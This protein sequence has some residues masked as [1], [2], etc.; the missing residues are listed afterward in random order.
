MVKAGVEPYDSE[1]VRAALRAGCSVLGIAK[2]QPNWS[3]DAIKRDAAAIGRTGLISAFSRPTELDL[4]TQLDKERPAD[5]ASWSAGV[6]R[7]HPGYSPGEL[8]KLWNYSKRVQ[9]GMKPAMGAAFQPPVSQQRELVKIA[10]HLDQPEARERLGLLPEDAKQWTLNYAVH[11]GELAEDTALSLGMMGLTQVTPVLTAAGRVLSRLPGGARIAKVAPALSHIPGARGAIARTAYRAATGAAEMQAIQPAFA[12]PTLIQHGGKAYLRSQIP[13]KETLPML[14]FGAI[15]KA[16]GGAVRAREPAPARALGPD[17]ATVPTEELLT[18]HTTW[19]E[20]PKQTPQ[21]AARLAEVQGELAKRAA[22]EVAPAPVAPPPVEVAK[23]VAPPEVAA[24]PARLAPHEVRLAPVQVVETSSV[25]ANPPRFQY[26]ETNPPESTAY[27]PA[28]AGVLDTWVD[29]ATGQRWVVNGNK[30]LAW[31]N[32]DAAPTVQVQDVLVDTADAARTFGA[33]KNISENTGTAVDAAKLFRGSGITPD[34]LQ[35]WGISLRGRVAR[36]G[37]GLSGLADDIFHKVAN[38]GELTEAQGSLIGRY[39]PDGAD[40]RVLADLIAEGERTGRKRIT[41]DMIPDVAAEIQSTPKVQRTETTLFGT[42]TT[43]ASTWHERAS[44][45]TWV[46]RE[47]TRDRMAFEVAAKNAERL[48]RGNNVIDEATSAAIAQK[49]GQAGEIYDRLK[50][51]VGPVNTALNAAAE[52]LA[53]GEKPDVVKADFY[54]ETYKAVEEIVAHG[55]GPSLIGPETVTPAAPPAV[56]TPAEPTPAPPVA[57]TPP[58]A[59]PGVAGK[60]PVTKPPAAGVEGTKPGVATK[61]GAKPTLA[62]VEEASAARVREAVPEAPPPA[63]GATIKVVAQRPQGPS[64]GQ[65]AVRFSDPHVEARWQAAT[66]GARKPSVLARLQNAA[67]T[68]IKSFR[69]TWIELPRGAKYAEAHEAL[70]QLPAKRADASSRTLTLLQDITLD[71][72][73]ARFDLFTR[74]VVLDD[75]TA[76]AAK[77][78]SLPFALTAETLVTEKVAVDAATAADSTVGRALSKRSDMMDAVKQDYIK[79]MGDIGPDL[80]SRLNRPDYFHHQVIEHLE[81]SRLWGTGERLKVPLGRGFLRRRYGSEKDIS[82]NY[83]RAEA[84]VVSQMLYDAEIARTIKRIGNNYDTAAQVKRH[85]KAAGLDDWHDAIPDGSR[86]WQPR[87]G[88]LFYRTPTIP[89]SVAQEIFKAGLEK[90]GVTADQIGRALAKGG[91]FEE[92]VLPKPLADTLDHIKPPVRAAPDVRVLRAWKQWTLINPRRVVGYNLRNL[93]GDIEPVFIMNPSAFR[94]VPQA[95]RELYQ[96]V[97]TTRPAVGNLK[98]WQGRGGWHGLLQAREMGMI[99]ELGMFLKLKAGEPG[100][101]TAATRAWHWYWR[102]GRLGT[103]FREAILRFA[104]YTE[105]LEQMKADV[106]K[107]GPGRPR[108]F[109]GSI[110][111]EIM[112]LK[113]VKDRAY[114]LSN[115]LLGAYDQISPSGQWLRD[116]LIP[117][118]SWKE[119]N[120]GREIRMFKNTVADQGMTAAVG[121][122]VVGKAVIR[123]PWT[124]YKVGKFA[125]KAT[126]IWAMMDAYNNTRFPKEEAELPTDVRGRPHLVFGRRPDG[127]IWYFDRLGALGDFLDWFGLG[128]AG[129]AGSRYIRDFLNGERTLPEIATEMAKGAP[130]EVVGGLT[131]YY[132]LPYEVLSRRSLYPD[133]FEQGPIRDLPEHIARGFALGEEF[134]AITGRPRRPYLESVP[135]L[136]GTVTDPRSTA[137]FE[138]LDLKSK[139]LEEHGRGGRGIFDSAKSRALW[140]WKRAIR[141]GDPEAKEKYLKEYKRL[142]GTEKGLAQ[143]VRMSDPLYGLG[144]LRQTFLTKLT[145]NQKRKLSLAQTYYEQLTVR[146]R[147]VRP[148]RVSHVRR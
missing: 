130:K 91:R 56:T 125:V 31:A 53:K 77:G 122:T 21:V 139:F 60:P 148:V 103:D 128:E 81:A 101:G 82:A 63:P 54:K 71:L 10:E 40:Q 109:G 85:A 72:D 115:E 137:Y 9:A 123:A 127:S 64:A 43:T 105:Y 88:N 61:A 106:A 36:D 58:A 133:V 143:S 104:N 37:L 124:A 126:A 22:P 86:T 146:P 26:K 94:R 93:S 46:K 14:A 89:E 65:P 120:F 35:A 102:A 8:R 112:A 17:V 90:V 49:A 80:S 97:K 20:M 135:T 19:T 57:L 52:R 117:F 147:L 23:A 7:D 118:W 87:E 39:L 108:N 78:E 92:M 69:R 79:A 99:D 141:Y 24:K 76:S 110:P 140:N 2:A 55:E 138:F 114:R 83:L 18:E 68:A 107:G 1:V 116:H 27:N 74:K 100:I 73:P 59:A 6:K 96:T 12:V 44:L 45:S 3:L 131:P 5:F 16:V 111:E 113:D 75:L 47:L 41:N 29:P 121:R 142:G 95:V 38:T 119:I 84:E 144:E 48:R 50:A 134:K 132:K 25:G 129:P 70:R 28:L 67:S 98:D 30:R 42:E 136:L 62:E 33:L 4:L 66:K 15:G 11:K 32:R 34:D 145:P 51:S 13:S